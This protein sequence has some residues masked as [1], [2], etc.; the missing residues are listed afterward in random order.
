MAD[1]GAAEKS[2]NA[3]LGRAADAGA[4]AR[5]SEFAVIEI[6]MNNP[7]EIAPRAH[8]RGRMWPW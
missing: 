4:D 3:R 2:Y 6:G 5:G 1:H 7:G 8:G